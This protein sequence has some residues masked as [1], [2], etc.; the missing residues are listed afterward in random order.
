MK[1]HLTTLLALGVTVFAAGE[2][3][4]PPNAR[5]AIIGD[6]I[7]E[8]KM[9]SKYME[10]Y[11]IACA[12]RQDVRV[13][14]FGWSGERAPGFLARMENDLSVLQPTAAT[15]CYG[16]NDGSYQPF[17]EKIGK[18]YED[19]MRGII[20]KFDKLGVM[21]VVVGSPGAVDTKFFKK[22]NFPEDKAAESYNDNLAHLRD[23]DRK[24]ASDKGKA[25]ADVHG[26]MFEAMGKAKAA[27]G[28]S[29]DVCGGDGF[30][31][32]PNGQLIMA[33]AFLK[34]L[35]CKGDIAEITVDMNGA[36]TASDGHKVLSSG[37]GKAEIESERYP[38]CFEGDAKSSKGT[39][40]ITPFFPFNE[41]L[42][43]F[44]LRVK[45]LGGE[46]AKVTWGTQTKEFAK[47][48]LEKGIN[49]AAEFDQTPFDESFKKFT[50]TVG[51]KQAFETSMIKDWITRFP[52][53][54]PLT[55]PA[56]ELE[57]AF[58]N[59]KKGFV[60]RQKALETDSRKV[61]QPVKHS[62]TIAQ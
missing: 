2:A 42:N 53:A 58:D 25:F 51:A 50:R 6:S 47:T 37:A 4:L 41:D 43:R 14:Q 60:A 11:L 35:G 8:Q 38:F 12:G 49:L 52:T 39:R 3:Q 56:P 33:Y 44:V 23:I 61:L 46:K 29:Y 7:T 48:Q 13:F 9:Y 26:A 30:H 31:P 62:I 55:K 19:A 21:N 16:M 22:P 57:A 24:L 10:V 5:L 18:T 36:A 54:A 32:G 1:L 59:L 28:D 34:G 20:E 15:T 27:L 40:S 45:N 17:N